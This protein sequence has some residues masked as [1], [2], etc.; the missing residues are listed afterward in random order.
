M[1]QLIGLLTL[2]LIVIAAKRW[3]FVPFAMQVQT[4]E[5]APEP[6]PE[7]IVELSDAQLNEALTGDA[8]ARAALGVKTDAGGA[9]DPAADAAK[10]AEAEAARKAQEEADRKA[11]EERAKAEAAK[12][13][14]AADPAAA[15]KGGAAPAAGAGGGEPPK[16]Y[17]GKYKTK[18]ELY[19]GFLSAAKALNYL[20]GVLEAVV[21]AAQRTGDVTKIE[22]LYGEL[23]KAISANHKAGD[24]AQPAPADPAAPGK[25]P[26]DTAGGP[27]P[28]ETERA[29]VRQLVFD[30]AEARLAASPVVRRLKARGIELPENLFQDRKVVEGFLESLETDHPALYI[31]F[32]Q[33]FVDAVD[34]SRTEV[35]ET[36]QAVREAEEKN[37]ATREADV[38]KI[39]DYAKQISLPLTDQELQAFAAAAEAEYPWIFEH[40]AGVDFL[41]PGALVDAFHL[42]HREKIAEQIRINAEIAGRT[43]AAK[44][45]EEHGRRNGG[46]ISRASLPASAPSRERKAGQIDTEDPGQLAALSDQQLDDLL[47]VKK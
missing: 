18:D 46:G 5:P 3:R 12:A 29:T 28:S 4:A 47:S 27:E 7:K 1:E 23:D 19:K 2:T 9:A 25:K 40:R 38:A 21:E 30:R 31:E 39:R 35:R 22:T 11:E 16:L 24:P 43:Q 8:A 20:P 17:A 13:A 33:A 6:E 36:Y 32:K 15:G 14:A 44:D 26:G 45:L 42:K 10:Q 34:G 41:K 37:P